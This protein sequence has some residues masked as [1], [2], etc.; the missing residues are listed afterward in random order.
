LIRFIQNRIMVHL[1]GRLRTT[2]FS[3]ILLLPAFAYSETIT[4]HIP[5]VEDSPELHLYFH[6]L[7]QKAIQETGHHPR[8]ITQS[9]PHSRVKRLLDFGEISIFWMVE[10]AERNK[11]YLP[12][13]IGITNGLIGKRILL[14][15]KG[16]QAIYD[17]V[18]TLEDFRALNLVGGMGKNWFD[19]KV[20]KAN[21]L[22]FEEKSGNWKAIF[23]MI[24]RGRSFHYFSRG[25]I[26]IISE[27]KQYPDLAIEKRLVLI[28]DR[29]FRFYLSKKGKNAARKYF[30]ILDKALKNAS[31]KGLIKRLVRKYWAGDFQKLHYDQRV[32]LHLK[33]PK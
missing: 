27:S 9:L 18:N 14:I 24:P 10:S 26:E 32:T 20:W 4:L 16:A 7:L 11:K 2:L 8:L 19:V 3:I 33:T 25:L 5:I 13:E 23:R 29:D 12:I 30:D 17:S 15:K 1:K 21:N 22:R 28:Y 6:E 31:S